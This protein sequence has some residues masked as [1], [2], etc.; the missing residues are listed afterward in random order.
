M[1]RLTAVLWAL[2][3]L[4]ASVSWASAEEYAEGEIYTVVGGDSLSAIGQRFGV[5]WKEI[6]RVNNI[7]PGNGYVIHPGNQLVIPKRSQRDPLSE[8]FDLQ[9]SVRGKWGMSGSAHPH[10]RTDTLQAKV[11]PVK[12]GEGVYLGVGGKIQ[13]TT[14]ETVTGWP[15]NSTQKT[16]T[17]T[18]KQIDPAGKFERG[19]TVGVGQK[20]DHKK[21]PEN[22]FTLSGYY[23]WKADENHPEMTVWAASSISKTIYLEVGGR[24]YLVEHQYF[25]LYVEGKIAL[26]NLLKKGV[27]VSVGVGI[28]D[29]QDIM[30]VGV[31]VEIGSRGLALTAGPSLKA[32]NLFNGVDLRDVAGAITVDANGQTVL[33]PIGDGPIHYDEDGPHSLIVDKSTGGLLCGTNPEEWNTH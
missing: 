18:V 13:H 20:T 10:T 25:R 30:D 29:R 11:F 8:R 24:V 22:L 4:L 17:A 2:L 12:T 5:P 9:G 33:A 32:N 14:G 31:G 28:T 15:I 1:N 23:T 21:P 27:L 3:L 19:A 26:D 7:H 6:A 16:L